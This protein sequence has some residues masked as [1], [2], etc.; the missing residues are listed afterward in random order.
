MIE[1]FLK[2][3]DAAWAILGGEP[4]GLKI[5]GSAALFLQTNYQRRTKDADVLEVDALSEKI[6]SALLESAGKKSALHAKHGIYLEIVGRGLPFLPQKPKFHK[7]DALCAGLKNFQVEA[8]DVV[9]VLVSKLKPFRVQDREDLRTM[10]HGGF[11]DHAIFIER[12]KSAV[13][14]WSYDSRATDLPKY[15]ENLHVVEREMF[16]VA[17]SE[18]EVPDWIAQ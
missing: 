17:E 9:D 16:F 6:Q 11:A 2:D 3:L 10:I 8:L 18:I 7:Q 4:I 12:F 5:I 14:R 13:D 15:V 1:G